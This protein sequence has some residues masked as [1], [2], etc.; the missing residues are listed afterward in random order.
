MKDRKLIES[1]S[2]FL[3]LIVIWLSWKI[4]AYLIGEEK[5]PVD[6]RI[7]PALSAQ[8]E[9]VNNWLR[10]LLLEAS[11]FLLQSAGHKTQ[12]I[13]NYILRIEGYGGIGLGNYCLGFQLMYYF[14]MIVLV[15]GFSFRKKAVGIISG[16][17]ALQFLNI[18]R[19]SGLVWIDA[20]AP[21]LKF[22][23]HDYIFN[24][25]VFGLLLLFY[26]KLLK[27]EHE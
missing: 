11:D 27:R 5:E 15:S 17:L 8:W 6:Q 13:E 1:A 18:L 10:I 7:F 22:I 21:R 4:F 20:F 2:F 23:S 16:I 14:T 3:K 24:I 26:W 9:S 25:A 12:L 19:I